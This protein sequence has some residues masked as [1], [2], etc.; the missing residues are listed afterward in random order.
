MV[1]K[2]IKYKDFNGQEREET[3][4]F[5]LSKAN[6][7]AM[8]AKHRG[9]LRTYLE[10][11]QAE[12]D[13]EKIWQYLSDIVLMAYGK[14]S[15]DGSRHIKNP[16]IREEFESSEAFSEL[17]MGLLSDPAGAAEF[18]NGLI[19]H[20]LRAQLGQMSSAP[21]PPMGPRPDV[22]QETGRNV[23]EKGAGPEH[24]PTESRMQPEPGALSETPETSRSFPHGAAQVLTA[25]EIREMDPVDLQRG[26][27][28]GR[29]KLS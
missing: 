9:G 4:F 23:F 13:T 26:L 28:E 27:V 14:R 22:T 12:Q 15:D 17:L 8:E 11:I 21:Q 18:I 29:Y 6:L 19:P 3:F 20:D 25:V 10:R 7:I 1:K 2:T 16:Q 24:V 5:H